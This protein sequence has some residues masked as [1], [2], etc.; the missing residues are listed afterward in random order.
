MEKLDKIYEK[1]HTSYFAFIGVVLFLVGLI[2]AILVHNNFSFM[3]K[4]ISDLSVPAW[5]EMAGFF[6]TFWFI[7]GVFMILFILGFTRYLQEQGASNKETNIACI[8]GV[9]SSVG[10]FMLA[11]FNTRDFE[12]LHDIAQ[13][14]FFFPGILY[15]ISYAYI[16]KKFT[17]FPLWQVLFNLVIAFFFLLYL[18]LFIINTTDP[19]S[20]L[21]AKVV[22]EWLFLFANLIWFIETGVFILKK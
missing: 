13:Y 14:I 10:I 20:L 9:L 21:E 15:L 19:T 1:F 12:L 3:S 5:N 7:T 18:I 4:F 2:P 11:L 22:A 17:D 8:F 16:E 6:S